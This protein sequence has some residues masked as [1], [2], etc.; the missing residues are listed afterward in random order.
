MIHVIS[1][2]GGRSS[3]LLLYLMRQKQ[4]NEG[5][6][7][8]YVFCDTGVEHPMTYRFIREIVKFWDIPLIILQAEINPILGEGN[9]Y[10]VWEPKDIQTR[11]PSVKPFVDMMSKYG[12]PYIGG[13]FCTDR[14]KLSPFKSYCDD[15]F[16]KGNYTTWIG[17]RS[18]EPK[19]LI[20]KNNIRYLADISDFD[21]NDVINWWK[22]QPFNLLI[23][24]HLGNCIFCIK[25]SIKK[26]GL[27]T[28]DEPSFTKQM[29]YH[30]ESNKVRDGHRSTSKKI[31]Y[32]GYQSLSSI[33]S[34][35]AQINR[36]DAYT[37]MINAKALETGSCTE[38]CEIY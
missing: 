28:I 24:E 4:L 27:A 1:L 23:P 2:S 34:I 19:R 21:K 13:A 35:Y 22:K 15:M 33:Q 11:M 12:T 38:S 31:M 8:R 14:L 7:V 3:G 32:R 30:I 17:I 25:K 29:I 6:D 16:G 10:S 20:L 5:L 9:S 37:S 26:I 36:T 18:D